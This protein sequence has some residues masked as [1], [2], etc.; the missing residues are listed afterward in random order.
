MN[1][2]R[3]LDSLNNLKKNT[4]TMDN[5]YKKTNQNMNF[6]ILLMTLMSL[7]TSTKIKIM[8]VFLMN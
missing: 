8:I 4:P 5:W 2:M 1:T 3:I 6:M 7:I